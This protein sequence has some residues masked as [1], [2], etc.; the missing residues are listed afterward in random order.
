MDSD[1]V[2]LMQTLLLIYILFTITF[3]FSVL[4][5]ICTS[6]SLSH[7]LGFRSVVSEEQWPLL[8]FRC[9]LSR[10]SSQVCK[11]SLS[12][13]SLFH[14]Y[15][16]LPHA[17]LNTLTQAQRWDYQQGAGGWLHF[18]AVSVVQGGGDG[19]KVGTG[20]GWCCRPRREHCRGLDQGMDVWLVSSWWLCAVHHSV[21][22]IKGGCHLGL[23]F[24][25][26]GHCCG[27][28]IPNTTPVLGKTQNS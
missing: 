12:L 5:N 17:G 11:P 21:L 7:K 10:C 6:W 23:G 8:L 13:S 28:K 18:R 4:P 19:A 25:F 3:L 24:S 26:A 15:H 14:C 20:E 27:K 22:Q 2:G 1:Y 9:A 16:S